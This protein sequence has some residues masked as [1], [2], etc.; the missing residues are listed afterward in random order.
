MND[1]HRPSGNSGLGEPT[2]EVA[3]FIPAQGDWTEAEYEH[4]KF[5]FSPL[6][7]LGRLGIQ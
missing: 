3:L 6:K 2:W 5:A 4:G 7:R 1:T